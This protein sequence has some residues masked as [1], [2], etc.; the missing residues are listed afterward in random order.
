MPIL[1]EP[2]QTFS[3]W[4][5]SDKDKPEASRPMF[6]AKAQSMRHQRKLLAV[7]DMIFA[8][9]V[10]VN[11]VFDSTIEHLFL[12]LAGW[13]NIDREFSKDSIEDLLTFEECRELLRKIAHNQRMSGN[14]KK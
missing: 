7:I 9:G 5:D 14:E 2:G 12:S 6:L 10:T 11:E 13:K 4:L 1:L 8:D 3:V